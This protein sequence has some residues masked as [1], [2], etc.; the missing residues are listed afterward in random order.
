MVPSGGVCLIAL[1]TRFLTARPN[2]ALSISTGMPRRGG[3]GEP[4]PLRPRDR[5]GARDHLGDQVLEPDQPGDSRSAPAWIL[6]SS[7][8]SSII[9]ASRS[10]SIRIC[11]W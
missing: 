11:E 8:R 3:P 1:I 5:L 9:A 7:N 2:S 6:D 4:D 10:V